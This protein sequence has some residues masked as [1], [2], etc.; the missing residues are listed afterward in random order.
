MA[1]DMSIP[2]MTFTL[3]PELPLELREEIWK[4]CLPRRICEVDTPL[5][6][7]VFG[8][9]TGVSSASTTG[10][11]PCELY[12]TTQMNKRPPI[13]SQVCHESRTVALKNGIGMS[14]SDENRLSG[15]VENT[16]RDKTRTIVHMNRTLVC[17]VDYEDLDDTPLH[18]LAS[19]ASRFENIGSMTLQYLESLGDP[20]CPCLTM[21]GPCT[22]SLSDRSADFLSQDLEALKQLPQWRVVI[23]TIVIH[24]DLKSA[25]GTGLFGFLGDAP[26]QIIDASDLMMMDAYYKLAAESEC[27]DKYAIKQDL[28]RSSLASVEQELREVILNRFKDEE[29]VTDS[30][31]PAV[32]FRLC[33]Q[34]CSREEGNEERNRRGLMALRARGRGRGRGR[35]TYRLLE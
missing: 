3:F 27:S 18:R 9:S 24:M 6:S 29:G 7:H 13:V 28:H 16:G 14:D 1:M 23:K 26:V 35:G 22:W 34:R 33:T 20:L 21:S 12:H 2:A 25:A 30:M 11:F 17:E 31:R 5:D 19:T 10:P 4:L 32:M 8:G 15:R